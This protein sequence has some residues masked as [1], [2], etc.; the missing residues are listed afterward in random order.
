MLTHQTCKSLGT[1]FSLKLNGQL[2]VIA[3]VAKSSQKKPSAHKAHKVK[4]ELARA[5]S[6]AQVEYS[7]D[8]AMVS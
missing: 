8:Q 1:Y 3:L 2:I 6:A 4:K 7:L 5:L